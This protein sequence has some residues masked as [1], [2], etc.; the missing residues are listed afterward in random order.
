VSGPARTLCFGDDG[1]PAADVAWLWVNSQVWPGWRVEVVTAEEP[2]IG[3]PVPEAEST[4]HPWEPPSPRAAFEEAGFVGVEHLTARADPRLVL[5]REVDLVVIGPRG[6]GLLKSLHLGSTAEWL[7]QHP[8]APLVIARSGHAVRSVMACND[9]SA[10]A[11][12]T[13]D[14]LASLPWIQDLAVTL[15]VVD[16]GRTDVEVAAATGRAALESAG[17]AVALEVAAGAPTGV[18]HDAIE[19]HAPDLV[20]LGTRGLTGLRRLRYGSTAGAIARAARC[21]VL[22][23]CAA[24]PDDEGPRA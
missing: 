21:S 7:L 8:V 16:D 2:P 18:I 17:A 15:M 12:R 20:A 9:G 13:I 5:S 6:P 23:A 3:P 11:R 14:A 22:L 10:D 4:P 24:H 19:R 1:S